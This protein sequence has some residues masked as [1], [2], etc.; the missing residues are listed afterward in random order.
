M[1][2]VILIYPAMTEGKNP[3]GSMLPLC[4]AWIASLLEKNGI[5]VKIVDFQIEDV[6]LVKLIQKENPLC[7]GLSGTTQSRFNSIEI[8]KKVKSVNTEI[9]TL[10]G[11]PHAT[12]AADDTLAHVSELDAVVRNEGEFTILEIMKTLKQDSRIDFS[13]ILGIS[14]R[15]NGHIIHNQNR[16]FLK[17]LDSLPFPAWHLF[18]MNCYKQ[19]LEYL[20][21]PAHV[22]LTSRGCPYNCSFCS[23]RLLWDN[24]YSRRSGV[25][26]VDELEYLV[27]H[28]SIQGFKIFDSTFTINRNHVLSI[29]DEI[30]KRN[31]DYLRWECEIRADTVDK[32]LLKSMKAAGCYY[33]DMGLESASS[34]VR[35]TISKGISLKQVENAINWCD[36][37]ELLLKL[38]VTVG[39]PTET[40]KEALKTYRFM[41]EYKSK[42]YKMATHVGIMIY[43]G[44]EVEK[45]AKLNGYLSSN[46][47]WST[48]F[49]ENSNKN[50]GSDPHVPLL[51]QPQMKYKH[52]AKIHFKLHWKPL[53]N[54]KNLFKK[55]CELFWKK[56]TRSKH[57]DTLIQLFNQRFNLSIRSL[58]QVK[59]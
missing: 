20:D 27:D 21:L 8:I 37:L 33:V 9:I 18:K 53:L 13:K 50:F 38:F 4:F 35:K 44:T 34:R 17:N 24:H 57:I 14:F 36:E 10:Y 32:Q 29:C 12:L 58:Q 15:E 6:D 16:P 3:H 5:S 7:V 11:G 22:I 26:V 45:F 42:V 31:L 46:F 30:K 1:S 49:Y 25:N 43:P 28:Y 56:D 2:D 23:A 55:I 19:E 51:I 41:E 48:P 52:L 39:H 40:Y 54:F 47:S 59:D